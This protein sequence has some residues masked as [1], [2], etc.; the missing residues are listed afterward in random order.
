MCGSTKLEIPMSPKNV[1]VACVVVVAVVAIALLLM[2]GPLYNDQ[3]TW[4]TSQEANRKSS[5]QTTGQSSPPSQ[6]A[7]KADSG[8]ATSD[9]ARG[10]QEPH[11]TTNR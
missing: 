2:R 9:S 5:Q 3:A 7:P 11:T 10:P 4:R 1:V 8:G 6:P